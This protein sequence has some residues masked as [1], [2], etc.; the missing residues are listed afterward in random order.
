MGKFCE[1]MQK[2]IMRKFRKKNAKFRIKIMRK[3][4]EKIKRKYRKK[5]KIKFCEIKWKLCEKYIA[6]K[7]WLKVCFVEGQTET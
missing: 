6:S 4:R 1:K 3:F 2:K 7:S 5:I